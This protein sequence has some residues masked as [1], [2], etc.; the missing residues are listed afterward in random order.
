[1][2][3]LYTHARPVMDTLHTQIADTQSHV[4]LTDRDGVILHSI[5]DADFVEKAYRVALCPGVSWA[6]DALGTNAIGT[7]LIAG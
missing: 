4:L 5:G 2:Q 1:S 7:A 3:S 6:E